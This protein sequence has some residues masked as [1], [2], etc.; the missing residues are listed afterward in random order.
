[1]F[2]VNS[3]F[4]DHMILQRHKPVVIWGKGRAGDKVT[5]SLQVESPVEKQPLATQDVI[6]DQSGEWMAELPAQQAATGVILLVTDGPNKLSFKDIGIGEV[7][8]AGGQSN[9]EY[10]VH[11]DANKSEIVQN[12]NSRQIRF[13]NVPQISIP[14][15]EAHFDYKYFGVWRCCTPEDLLHFSSVAYYFSHDLNLVLDIPV[16]IVGCNWGGT[17]ACAWVEER[18]LRNTPA[19]VWLD[20]YDAK[21]K[22]IDFEQDKQLY[23]NHPNSDTSQPLKVVEGLAGKIMYPGLSESEQS[24]MVRETA[25]NPDQQ[26][27]INGGPHHQNRPGGL[28]K[29]MVS[30]ITAFKVRGVIW[31]QGESDSPHSDV[32]FSTFS[33][34][35]RCW[36]DAWGECLPFL[37]VQ[38]APFSRWLA[39]NGGAFPE[40]RRQQQKVADEIEN[41]WMVSSGDA[42]M[43]IDIHPKVKKPIGQRLAL[44][45]QQRIYKRDILSEAPKLA[46]VEKSKDMICIEF[47]HADGLYLKGN[48]VNALLVEDIRGE[49]IPYKCFSLEG[50]C[51]NLYGNFENAVAVKFAS[52]PYYQVNLYNHSHVPALPFS[53]RF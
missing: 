50:G 43:E 22:G 27:P 49:S 48:S 46:R 52:T 7:W 25:G 42:G 41:T 4:G 9:M 38:L 39:L 26:A 32:Y 19:Q 51:L 23:L 28:Y 24:E 1:M 5:V 31:Y 33:Q 21:L 3:I 17:P 15:M 47:E 11:F 37:F 20:E 40:L 18:Y 34:L 53:V 13:F 14:E 10:H 8:V 36:R 29:N 2:S 45:A 16:G 12:Q 6:V 30:H 35:I 44:L